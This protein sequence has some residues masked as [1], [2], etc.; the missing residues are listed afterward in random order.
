MITETTINR[1]EYFISHY[2]PEQN[3][4]S[5]IAPFGRE[6]EHVNAF[7]LTNEP[8]LYNLNGTTDIHHYGHQLQTEYNIIT[9]LLDNKLITFPYGE[10]FDPTI[11]IKEFMEVQD[12]NYYLF[13]T[14]NNTG[15]KEPLNSLRIALN[16]NHKNFK[17]IYQ[18]YTTYINLN[19]PI[20]LFIL[21]EPIPINEVL[22]IHKKSKEDKLTII[23]KYNYRLLI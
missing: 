11:P 21:N 19:E 16:D 20:V 23:N 18:I 15:Y 6:T 8:N 10:F 7:I 5:Y 13:I 2:T 14:T 12:N 3:K 17:Y 1:I 9:K 4:L 22:N